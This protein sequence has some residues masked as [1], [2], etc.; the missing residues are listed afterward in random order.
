VGGRSRQHQAGFRGRPAGAALH[1]AQHLGCEA[2]P[3]AMLPVPSYMVA[4]APGAFLLRI[5]GESMAGEGILPGD[6]VVVKPQELATSGDLVAA[7]LLDGHTVKRYSKGKDG[8]VRLMPSNPD[9]ARFQPIPVLEEDARV[10][11]RVVGLI[12]DYS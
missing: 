7:R 5:E 1:V 9:T 3:E 4:K 8:V 2:H 10:I 12:R 6:L 11:G